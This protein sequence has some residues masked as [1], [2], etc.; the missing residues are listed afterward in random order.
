M[1]KAA[2]PPL[3]Q[4]Q[5]D[6]ANAFFHFLFTDQKEFI[7]SGPGGVGKTFLMGH[8]IDT[9]MP[10]YYDTCTLMGLKPE[11]DQVQMT[12]TTNKAAEALSLATGRPTK[13]IHSFLNL[14]VQDDYATGTSKLTRTGAWTVHSRVI[15]F[16][17]EASMIDFPLLEEILGSTMNCK[18]VYVGDHCQLAPI[19]EP[20]SPIYRKGIPFYELTEPMRNNGQPALMALCRQLRHTVETGEFRPIQIVP[21]AIDWCDDEDMQEG[22]RQI[23]ADPHH[24]SRILAYTNKRVTEFNDFIRGVRG[25]GHE[26]VTGECLINNNAIQ[27]GGRNG[28]MLSVEE[29]VEIVS[30]SGVTIKEFIDDGAELEIRRCDLTTRL[31]ETFKDVP[32]PVDRDHFHSLIKYFQGRKNWNRYFYLKNTYPD[33]R[34]RDANTAYKAQGSTYDTV[35]I[36]LGNI[37]ACNVP[38]QVARMLYVAVSRP[39]LRIFL[40]GELAAKYGGLLH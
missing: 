7:I 39:R 33:L 26:Y 28:R 11:Y 23:F 29:E 15:L 8:L 38:N 10:R 6:A 37:S 9:I 20:L 35:F 4:G 14:K 18:I 1:S 34:P 17:D 32:L 13:T 40:Y 19:K 30:Q 22:M 12:A 27:L 25:L 5:E 2:P 36:D 31:G 24:T 16:I 3:N 21:G